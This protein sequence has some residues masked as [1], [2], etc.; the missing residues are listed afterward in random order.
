MGIGSSAP[1]KPHEAPS[2]HWGHIGLQSQ[3]D[4]P[5]PNS[6]NDAQNTQ[7]QQITQKPH[8]QQIIKKAQKKPHH[9]TTTN[10]PQSN[11]PLQSE[12]K[13]RPPPEPPPT[14]R[15]PSPEPPPP[16]PPPEPPPTLLGAHHTTDDPDSVPAPPRIRRYRSWT[17]EPIRQAAIAHV[18]A[19][20]QEAA[21]PRAHAIGHSRNPQPP[22]QESTQD[23]SKATQGNHHHQQPFS[24]HPQCPPE[25]SRD[26]HLPPEETPTQNQDQ[27]NNAPRPTPSPP[28]FDL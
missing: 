21:S 20:Q 9:I 12:H 17:T 11:A 16:R 7:K 2:R 14:P 15:R 28:P 5:P 23:S 13:R 19:L 8:K 26:L 1:K 25:I 18:Q 4:V 10:H 6:T 24:S 22:I 27:P 3:P